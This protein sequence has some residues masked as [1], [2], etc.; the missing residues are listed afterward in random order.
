VEPRGI[1]PLIMTVPPADLILG[2]CGESCNRLHSKPTRHFVLC[3]RLPSRASPW[4]RIAF[5]NPPFCRGSKRF[6]WA[7]AQSSHRVASLSGANRPPLNREI[8]HCRR[9]R[10]NVLLLVQRSNCVSSSSPSSR[11][12]CWRNSSS[13][14]RSCSPPLH[15]RFSFNVLYANRLGSGDYPS[16]NVVELVSKGLFLLSLQFLLSTH[17]SSIVKVSSPFGVNFHLSKSQG[18]SLSVGVRSL[19]LRS[20]FSRMKKPS[21]SSFTKNFGCDNCTDSDR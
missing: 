10:F 2:N 5:S 3:K 6:A 15:L 12:T 8:S 11:S 7:C 19:S 1:E 9:N 21:F 17:T 13:S 4:F 20:T 14:R 16:Y 18:F